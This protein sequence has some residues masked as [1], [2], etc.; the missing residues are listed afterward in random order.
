MWECSHTVIN[1][2]FFF[3]F[4]T[5]VQLNYQKSGR[6]DQMDQKKLNSTRDRFSKSTGH[7][8]ASGS[9]INLLTTSG[10]FKKIVKAIS[11]YPRLCTIPYFTVWS[12]WRWHTSIK[13]PPLCLIMLKIW[14]RICQTTKGSFVRVSI[15][16]SSFGN[17]Q[18]LHSTW[19]RKMEVTRLKHTI[20]VVA[21]KHR[22]L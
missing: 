15:P 8:G 12:S 17:L 9:N 13:W 3:L 4:C 2:Y 5:R 6:K 20:S 19:Q 18:R 11:L 16:L 10:L 1:W 14:S 21:W 22:G 7:A